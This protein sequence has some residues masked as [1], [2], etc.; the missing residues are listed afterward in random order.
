MAKKPNK[1]VMDGRRDNGQFGVGNKCGGSAPY[2]KQKREE[3]EL[4]DSMLA[5]AVP[6]KRLKRI[7]D[8]IAALAEDDGNIEAAKFIFDR[9]LGKV[10]QPLEHSGADG[11]PVLF[12]WEGK[13]PK[14][15]K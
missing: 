12:G 5:E 3:R 9:R 13:C 6:P 2:S 15:K 10:A 1:T 7:A 4:I 14:P 11:G 8:K